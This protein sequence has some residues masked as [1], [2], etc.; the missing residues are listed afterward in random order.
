MSHRSWTVT[1]LPE[2]LAAFTEH[3]TLTETVLRGELTA[4]ANA[5]DESLSRDPD[6]LGKPLESD[7][8]LRVWRVEFARLA[9]NVQNQLFPDDRIVHVLMIQL[10]MRKSTGR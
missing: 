8:T 4:I 1:W 6:R 7:S 5:V 2:L 9:A 3:W 10:S